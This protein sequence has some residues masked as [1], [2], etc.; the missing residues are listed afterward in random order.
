ME[1]PTARYDNLEIIHVPQHTKR[2]LNEYLKTAGNQ[3]AYVK[4]MVETIKEHMAPGERGLGD[5]QEDAL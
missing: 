5:L 1:V 3:R 2:R 4:W